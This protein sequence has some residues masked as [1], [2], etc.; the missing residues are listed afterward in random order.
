[1]RK[2][3][4]LGILLLSGLI[5]LVPI[6]RDGG[7]FKNY[8]EKYPKVSKALLVCSKDPRWRECLAYQLAVNGQINGFNSSANFLSNLNLGEE[9]S[10]DC[11]N[12]AHQLGLKAF[13]Y[14][15]NLDF[16]NQNSKE[17]CQGGFVHGVFEGAAEE[18]Y[19][20]KT[21]NFCKN[22][23]IFIACQHAYG[24][25]LFKLER[26]INNRSLGLC[27]QSGYKYNCLD[28]LFM[29]NSLLNQSHDLTL[30]QKCQD[31]DT[32][33]QEPCYRNAFYGL[34]SANL[35][36]PD[37]TNLKNLCLKLSSNNFSACLEGLGYGSRSILNN[38]SNPQAYINLCTINGKTDA[39]C[40]N[41]VLM[42]NSGIRENSFQ[43]SIC[44]FLR[45]EPKLC[46]NSKN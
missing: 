32:W 46:L 2:I 14:Y 23:E 12:I 18:G 8:D 19:D 45:N 39:G 26:G 13:K 20:I 35:D 43:A 17:G 37:F 33:V 36:A 4:L 11:H 5:A 1:M 40:I 9:F 3:A 44:E 42:Q 7:S 27:S 41:Y 34:G 38:V 31:F 29:A 30:Y 15:G 25:Y 22:L 24:H 28:G 10:A 6:V 16:I 21:L